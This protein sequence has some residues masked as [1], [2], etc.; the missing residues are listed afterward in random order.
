MVLFNHGRYDESCD[1][2]RY[3]ISEKS[4]ITDNINHHF[5]T[6]RI[7]SYSSLPIEK[8][9]TFY[10]VMTLIKSVVNINKNGYCCNIFL[11]KG[12]YKDK[13]ITLYF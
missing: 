13:S 8:T 3:L 10:N 1:W 6:I 5:T 7:D 9:L 12:L 11:E 2:V 4:G